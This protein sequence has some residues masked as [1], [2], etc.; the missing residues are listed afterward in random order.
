MVGFLSVTTYRI[1][2]DDIDANPDKG[3]GSIGAINIRIED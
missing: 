2:A 1:G 3:R